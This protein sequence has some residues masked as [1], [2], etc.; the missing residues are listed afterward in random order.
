M[1]SPLVVFGAAVWPGGQP[2]PSLQRRCNAAIAYWQTGR[3]DKIVPS[4]GLGKHAPTEAE[5][6]ASIFRSAG[7]DDN[8]IVREDQ[9]STTFDTAR[10]VQPLFDA[11]DVDTY[12]L[13]TDR[14]HLARARLA[15]AAFGMRSV[16]LSA[17]GHTPNSRAAHTLKQ[18]LREIPGTAYYTVRFVLRRLFG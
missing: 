12:F 7:I 11:K 13:V 3:Y 5:V 6:M 2:S 9:A 1:T 17:S 10:L 16:G 4:G 18:W 8:D 14:Y 15:F